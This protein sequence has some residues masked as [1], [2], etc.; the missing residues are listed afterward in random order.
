MKKSGSKFIDVL[1]YFCLLVVMVIGMAAIVGSTGGNSGGDDNGGDG[2]GGGDQSLTITGESGNQVNLNGTWEGICNPDS[3]DGSSDASDLTVSGSSFTV[4][5]SFWFNSTNCSGSSD[6]TRNFGG[7]FTI[8]D[9]V[10]VKL[11]GTNVTATKIDTVFNSAQAT[12]L[13]PDVLDDI[14]TDQTCGYNNWEVGVA[15]DI[16]G[17]SCIADTNQKDVIYID[18][19]VDPDIFYSG[20]EDEPADENGYPT[21]ID[22]NT[23]SERS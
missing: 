21:V 18:D 16:L 6:A 19:T 9:E 7:T 15:K 8:G 14:N 13:N 5:Q 2:N 10:T 12:V 11:S 17:T 23:E 1:R 20:D 3:V 4:I 22:L